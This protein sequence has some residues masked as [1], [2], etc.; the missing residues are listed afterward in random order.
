MTCTL[1]RMDESS[2]PSNAGM[3]CDHEKHFHQHEIMQLSSMVQSADSGNIATQEYREMCPQN[4][5]TQRNWT[6][7]LLSACTHFFHLKI[8]NTVMI[9]IETRNQRSTH[10]W[11]INT[12]PSCKC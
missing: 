11:P 9:T 4:L 1:Y 8:C 3:L 6:R 10:P 5:L 12:F 2:K 7:E